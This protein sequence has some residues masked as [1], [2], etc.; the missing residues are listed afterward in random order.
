MM[1]QQLLEVREIQGLY[2]PWRVSERLLQRIWAHGDYSEDRLRTLDG[3]IVRVIRPG[4]WNHQEGPDF[5]DAVLYI[6]GKQVR[7]D[8]EIHFRS[9]DWREHG[10][11]LDPAFSSVV[12]RVLLYPPK[13]GEAQTET[14]GGR[15]PE[16][17]SLL[18][19]LESS[20]EEY[21]EEEAIRRFC[22][23]DSTNFSD[24]FM[25]LP[26][27]DRADALKK[28]SSDR[29]EAK[30]NLAAKRLK[31]TVWREV[32]HQVLLEVLGYRR[33][34]APMSSIALQYPLS[35]LKGDSRPR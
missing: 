26:L 32:C 2:G 30:L 17:C 9:R 22:G 33:N 8:V 34:R 6:D 16:A 29:W 19:A 11:H 13:I 3:K 24:V 12:L 7:G 14:L 20:L 1:N 28:Y 21:A 27:E 23:Q 18:E 15:H 10:H 31:S 5:L 4:S 25:T 35:G